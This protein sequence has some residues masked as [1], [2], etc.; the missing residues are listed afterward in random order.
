MPSPTL[1]DVHVEAPLSNIAIAYRNEE[2]I[3]DRVFPR[4]PVMHKTDKYFVFPKDA[5][6]RDEVAVRAPGT[7]SQSADYD[8]TTAS[9]VAI[10]WAINKLVT[11]EERLNADNPLEPDVQA[12]EF[13]M[14]ALMRAQERRV[15]AKVM[16]SSGWSYSATPTN[17]WSTDISDPYGDILAAVDGVIQSIGR[18]PNVAVMSWDVWQHLMQHPDLLDR[19]KY[20]RPGAMVAESDIA[21]WFGFDKVLVGMSIYNSAAEGGTF[22]ASYIWSDDFWC[23]YVPPR[24]ALRVPAAGYV[25]EWQTRQIRRFRRQEERTD[26]IEAAHSVAEVTSAS[27]AA[28]I[29]YNAV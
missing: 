3:W 27:D 18:R 10:E 16:N 11:D 25:L 24:P 4:V 28:G 13:T 20:T 2:Y 26:V 22:S 19:I 21:G 23:G 29:I 12:V 15:A 9:Y 8:L 1:H 6:F 14:D 7:R 5:W 17:Q